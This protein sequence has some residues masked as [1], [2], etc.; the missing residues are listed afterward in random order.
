MTDAHICDEWTVAADAVLYRIDENVR[1]HPEMWHVD[2]VY[3]PEHGT[4]PRVH[5]WDGTHTVD[6]WWNVEDLWACFEP[7]GWSAKGKPTYILTRTIGHEAYPR[8]MMAPEVYE[9]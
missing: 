2:D 4:R 6:E 9:Q 8:D 3:Y 7:A 5:I 1:N